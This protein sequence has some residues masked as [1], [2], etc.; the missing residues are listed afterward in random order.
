MA[1]RLDPKLA[2]ARLNLGVIFFRQSEY[3]RAGKELW[4]AVRLNPRYALAYFNLGLVRL[5]QH[6]LENAKQLFQ[7]VEQL[8]SRDATVYYNMGL[9]Y[10]T[11]GDNADAVR[12]FKTALSL[13][14]EW[15]EPRL[16]LVSAF[17]NN[18]MCQ[19]AEELA[20]TSPVHDSRLEAAAA[21]CSSG[22]RP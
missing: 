4:E 2:D 13:K 6:D 1:A 16:K 14:P 11:I 15:V 3:T 8:G 10:E 5:A 9:I 12:L 21:G 22:G 17:A 7:K 20:R 19:E 18:G